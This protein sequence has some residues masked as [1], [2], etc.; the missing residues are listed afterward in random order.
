MKAWSREHE[1]V[2]V[3]GVMLVFLGGGGEGY[4]IS[5]A[6]L[7][8]NLFLLSLFSL[9]FFQVWVPY[10]P[11]PKGPIFLDPCINHL[12]PKIRYFKSKAQDILFSQLALH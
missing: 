11:P 1:W 8:L 12:H 9:C 2:L 6:R 5:G 4:A 10:S 7:L 3:E